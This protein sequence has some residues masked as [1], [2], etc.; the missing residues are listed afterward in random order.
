MLT[1]SFP[2]DEGVREVLQP[3]DVSTV[4]PRHEP[5][6][7]QVVD[8]GRDHR[9]VER[10]AVL[11]QTHTQ[12]VVHLLELFPADVAQQCPYLL[13]P[14]VARLQGDY[15]VSRGLGFGKHTVARDTEGR[16]WDV[17][18]GKVSGKKTRRTGVEKK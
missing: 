5:G 8:G 2:H 15:C 10:L 6:R 12:A 11:V 9:V 13:A 3:D 16:R 4:V 17:K 7:G 1:V 14:R 18:G